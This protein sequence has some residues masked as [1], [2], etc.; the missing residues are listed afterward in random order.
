[1]QPRCDYEKGAGAETPREVEELEIRRYQQ[2]TSGSRTRNISKSS[3]KQLL[4]TTW[5]LLCVMQHLCP[6]GEGWQA[7]GCIMLL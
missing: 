3:H 1:M 6:V 5:S 2:A 7:G 4:M